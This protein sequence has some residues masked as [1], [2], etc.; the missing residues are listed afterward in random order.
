MTFFSSLNLIAFLIICWHSCDISDASINNFD[1]EIIEETVIT[2]FF[3]HVCINISYVTLKHSMLVK[4]VKKWLK[5]ALLHKLKKVS[6]HLFLTSKSYTL[7][8]SVCTSNIVTISTV[9]IKHCYFITVNV[10]LNISSCAF[11]TSQCFSHESVTASE[12][13]AA[14]LT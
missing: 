8:T 13:T 9:F 6:L 3:S 14:S 5:S 11:K 12:I 7:K 4:N 2:S 10:I 1:C